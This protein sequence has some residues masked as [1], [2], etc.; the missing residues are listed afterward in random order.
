MC[1]SNGRTYEYM[2][3]LMQTEPP[4]AGIDDLFTRVQCEVM[5]LWPPPDFSR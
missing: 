3:C 4:G 1:D 5:P 2:Y